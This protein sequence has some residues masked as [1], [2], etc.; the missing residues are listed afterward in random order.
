MYP[1][2]IYIN[3]D[4]DELDFRKYGVDIADMVEGLSNPETNYHREK[5][6]YTHGTTLISGVAGERI[7]TVPIF[8]TPYGGSNAGQIVREINGLL[9]PWGDDPLD[10]TEGTL[11]YQSC[12]D[13]PLF[14]IR[15]IPMGELKAKDERPG[16]SAKLV[17]FL[18]PYPFFKRIPDS[19]EV[20]EVEEAGFEIPWSIPTSI[21]SPSATLNLWN[22]GNIPTSPHI[23]VTGPA[24]DIWI[25]HQQSGAVMRVFVTLSASQTLVI[26]GDTKTITVGGNNAAG[27]VQSGSQFISMKKGANTFDIRV[28]SGSPTIKVAASHYYSG[29]R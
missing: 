18:C 22:F 9:N 27:Y 24:S 20:V 12:E 1:S 16:W 21:D 19:V 13:D 17:D 23:E 29:V 26:D 2:L 28:D 8:V 10:I 3:P 5:T 14:E 7:I 4:G 11:R 15:A 25:T 6:P